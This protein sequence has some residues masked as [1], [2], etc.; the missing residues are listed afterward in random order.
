[1]IREK[2][3]SSVRG[4]QG[5]RCVASVNV[6]TVVLESRAVVSCEAWYTIF[7]RSCV[8]LVSASVQG[9]SFGSRRVGLWGGPHVDRDFAHDAFWVAGDVIVF[10]CVDYAGEA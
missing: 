7:N 2:E 1:M 4:K 6:F 5:R 10:G 8:F 3:R 9:E